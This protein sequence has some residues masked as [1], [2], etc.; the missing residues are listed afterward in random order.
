MY[1]ILNSLTRMIIMGSL[2]AALGCASGV[3]KYDY[4]ETTNTADEITALR[5]EM[6]QA[7]AR[8]IDAFA[9]T[10]LADAQKYLDRAQ[11]LQEKGAKH[12][13][14][15][16]ALG[17]AKAYWNNA[18]AHATDSMSK[19]SEVAKARQAAL[20]AQA[21]QYESSALKNTDKDLKDVT[22]E[23]EKNRPLKMSQAERTDLQNKYLAIELQSIKTVRLGEAY[24]MIE[25][26][27]K[28]KAEKLAPKTY[29]EAMAKYA[30]AQSVINTDRHNDTAIN[31][32][33]EDATSAA[34]KALV[35]TR[36]AKN[37]KSES[38]EAAALRMSGQNEQ[39][40]QLDQQLTQEQKENAENQSA[41]NQTR[42]TEAQLQA[43]KKFN[44]SFEMA[45][46]EFN[47]KEAEV[48]RQGDN[49]LIRFRSIQ[50]P[51]GR[52][53]LPSTAL[54]SLR[55]IK[56]IAKDLDAQKIVVEGHTD[57]IGTRTV[58]QKLSQER[59]DAVAKYIASEDIL[60][61]DQIES[62]GF[63][64]DRPLTS[65]KTKA[66]RAENRRVDVIISPS[67]IQ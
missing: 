40:Q 8:Q 2:F 12:D 67:T 19:L 33:V 64:F 62:K 66:G 59:A 29:S 42:K 45:R 16:N 4:T 43:E 6:D 10:D 18:E 48:Y 32:A 1:R 52:A 11:K 46:K 61:S 3:K 14:V 39:I 47:P 28:E 7:P 44:D 20:T 13:D 56:D 5:A 27:K 38:P 55:K 9:P 21:P 60:K 24:G 34:R 54:N 37:V 17:Y 57:S 15:L 49:L 30:S 50:F 26:A 65:N 51:S 41:L 58:N 36:L 31:T 35:V 63:G 53:E 23:L 22:A 25:A